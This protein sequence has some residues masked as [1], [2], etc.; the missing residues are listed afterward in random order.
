MVILQSIT[1]IGLESY[2][3]Y[4]FLGNYNDFEGSSAK[5]IPIYLIIFLFSQIFQVIICWDALIKQN[6]IQIIGF[7]IFNAC[8]FAYALFQYFQM[9]QLL[10]SSLPGPPPSQMEPF[11]IG[12]TVVLGVGVVFFGFLAFK[13]YL[14]F[15]WQIY[16]KI[17]ADPKMKSMYRSYQIFLTILKLDFFFFLA[18]SIQFVV[19]VLNPSDAEFTV[20]IIALPVTIVVLFLAVY[21]LKREDRVVMSMFMFG[22]VLAVAYFIFKLVRMYDVMQSGKYMYS[23]NYLTFFASLSLF[24]VVVTFINAV[25]CF[26]NFGKGLQEHIN[27]TQYGP[28]SAAAGGNTAG[29]HCV[30]DVDMRERKMT[31][32]D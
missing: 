3:A 7:V 11:L 29:A 25:V 2:I 31:L 30:T 12:V 26:M 8:S 18:F 10:N 22:C 1:V 4:Y 14:E 15:G 6:T 13:L 19:L 23:R 28:N 20:T 9:R 5:G 21:G 27:Q 24:C 32:V 17:G 16:K